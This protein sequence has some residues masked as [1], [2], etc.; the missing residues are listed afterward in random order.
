M[1]VQRVP[2]YKTLIEE[3]VKVTPDHYRDKEL[4]NQAVVA[5]KQTATFIDDTIRFKEGITRVRVAMQIFVCFASVIL[6]H[7]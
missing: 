5:I 4:L 3:L 7:F 1:P 6:V 2:R